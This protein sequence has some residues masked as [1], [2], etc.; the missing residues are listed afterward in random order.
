MASSKQTSFTVSLLALNTAA[1]RFWCRLWKTRQPHSIVLGQPPSRVQRR[2]T[3]VLLGVL[4]LLLTL[5]S[6]PSSAQTPPSNSAAEAPVVLDG[7]VL[8]KVRNFGNFTAAD[9][10]AI[11]NTNLEQELQSSL[12]GATQTP[13]PVILD[14]VQ[15][16]QQT[17]IRSR[18]SLSGVSA[19]ETRDLV[20]LSEGDVIP[21]SSPLRQANIWRGWIEEA[22]RQAQLERTP[23]YFRQALLFCMGVLLG[24]IAVHFGL[25]F[26]WRLASRQLTRWLGNPASPLHPWEPSAKLFLQL[27]L[28]GLEAGLWTAVGFYITDIFPQARSWRYK[29]FNFLTSPIVS[30]G[31]S[32]YSALQLLLL[33]AFTVG[34]WFAVSAIT[35]LFKFY[36][37]SRT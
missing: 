26:L 18:T 4:T 13:K 20:T 10:A 36:I 11:I 31:E 7:R 33:V 16:N 22:L 8:F 15:E 17:I 32:N 5:V 28:L 29:L 30:L 24:A 2:W 35:R 27:A 12:A 23:A 3:V 34:L 19:Q 37:L 21:G 1:R 9:R 14:V 25:G 6:V